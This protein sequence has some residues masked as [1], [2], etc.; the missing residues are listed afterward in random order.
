MNQLKLKMKLLI[1]DLVK[2]SNGRIQL[3]VGTTHRED[4]LSI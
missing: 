3:L 4:D 1:T 2:V